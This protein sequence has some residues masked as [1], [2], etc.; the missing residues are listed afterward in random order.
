MPRRPHHF[1]PL[2]LRGRGTTPA[3]RGG[4]ASFGP[5]AVSA[6]MGRAYSMCNASNK[7]S[8]FSFLKGRQTK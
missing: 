8:I 7:Q 1:P 4:A 2:S 5:C 3:L 6:E